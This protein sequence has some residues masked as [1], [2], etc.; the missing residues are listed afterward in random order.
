LFFKSNNQVRQRKKHT[1]TI[2]RPPQSGHQAKEQLESIAPHTEANYNDMRLH[3][4]GH[5]QKTRFLRVF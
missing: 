2:A 5:S 3:V 4:L 1:A